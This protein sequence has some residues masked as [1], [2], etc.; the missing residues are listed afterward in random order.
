MLC[1]T[2]TT[3]PGCPCLLAAVLLCLEM[4]CAI[5]LETKWWLQLEAASTRL[6]SSDESR[7]RFCSGIVGCHVAESSTRTPIAASGPPGAASRR[8]S[9][10]DGATAAA[11]SSCSSAA[12]SSPGPVE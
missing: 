10:C 2:G 8:S 7:P 12:R 11:W 3:V 9:C 4:L 1:P 6:V 5:Q